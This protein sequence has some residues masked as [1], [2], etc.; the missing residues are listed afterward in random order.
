[1]NNI[2]QLIDELRLNKCSI[3][4]NDRDN[5]NLIF[6]DKAELKFHVVI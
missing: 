6:E 2:R 4:L 3:K 1:M 5:I